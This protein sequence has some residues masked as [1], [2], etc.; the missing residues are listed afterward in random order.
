MSPTAVGLISFGFITGGSLLG[1]HLSQRLPDH[2]LS[3]ESREA[4]KMTWGIIATLT[5]LV[6]GLLIASAKTNFDTVNSERTGSAA[7]L[8]VLNHILVRYGPQAVALRQNLREAVASGIKRDW[9]GEPFDAN[10]TPAPPN[11][12]VIEAFQDKL[13]QLTPENDAQRALLAR[14]EQICGELALE[15]WLVIEQSGASLPDV[16]FVAVVFWLTL[17]FVGLGL[18]APHNKTTLA[19]SILGSISVSVAIFIISDM[20]YPLQGLISVSSDSMRDVWNHLSQ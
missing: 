10:V 4:V 14:A 2:H 6:L 5:A 3:T 7:K 12:N 9:P 13:S 17:L 15:R 11:S 18:L 20:S 8:I 1:F 19:A 16:L